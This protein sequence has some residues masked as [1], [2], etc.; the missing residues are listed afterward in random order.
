MT[1][2]QELY[3]LMRLA[4][5][6]SHSFTRKAP[7]GITVCTHCDQSVLYWNGDL[8]NQI[9]VDDYRRAA[10]EAMPELL[11]TISQCQAALAGLVAARKRKQEVGKDQMYEATK[12]VA[13]SAAQVALTMI[14]KLDEEE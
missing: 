7:G 5:P 8:C 11:S 10:A 3:G 1:T 9:A 6:E 13:W 4:E 2:R 14:A 12:A